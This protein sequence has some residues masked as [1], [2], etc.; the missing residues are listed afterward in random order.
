MMAVFVELAGANR[1]WA[2]AF[3]L[4]GGGMMG[5][6]FYTYFGRWTFSM[7]RRYGFP[8]RSER[9]QI[10]R[11]G[12]S[13]KVR[14]NRMKRLIVRVRQRHGLLGIAALTPIFLTVPIGTF[15]ANLIEP[16]K[17]RVLLFM[18][19]AFALWTA[20]F[21]LLDNG[22]DW[23]LGHVFRSALHNKP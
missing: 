11:S 17:S 23:N 1:F 18:A 6:L 4:W 15:A 16:K 20:V 9:K 14:F 10:E 21:C 13:G 8:Y 12:Q 22:F 19:I 5:V 3:R 7:W 2:S